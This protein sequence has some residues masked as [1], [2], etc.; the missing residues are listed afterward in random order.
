MFLVNYFLLKLGSCLLIFVFVKNLKRK[1]G[2]WELELEREKREAQG[3][4]TKEPE[5]LIAIQVI[6]RKQFKKINL[7]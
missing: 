4:F 1:G 2:V 5:S 7:L 3:E 6:Y